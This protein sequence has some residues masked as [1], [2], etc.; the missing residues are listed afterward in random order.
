MVFDIVDDIRSS[1]GFQRNLFTAGHDKIFVN[2]QCVFHSKIIELFTDEDKTSAQIMFLIVTPMTATVFVLEETAIRLGLID[3]VARIRQAFGT[4]LGILNPVISDAVF[5]GNQ[6]K[7]NQLLRFT[8]QVE[9]L[10]FT[11]NGV[12]SPTGYPIT[13]LGATS[14]GGLAS[15]QRKYT[16]IGIGRK[17]GIMGHFIAIE[18]FTVVFHTLILNVLN[19]FLNN[20]VRDNHILDMIIH[21]GFEVL[22]IGVAVF[23]AEHIVVVEIAQDKTILWSAM[24]F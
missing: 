16:M 7:V 18:K 23:I 24:G 20:P 19:P 5:L 8:L 2:G 9:L 21:Q 12:G 6:C 3:V 4:F 22:G 17:A 10:V 1:I 14:D 13:L 15:G 11:L